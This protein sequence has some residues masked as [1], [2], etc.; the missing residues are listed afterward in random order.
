MRAP[1]RVVAAP[2]A[3]LFVALSCVIAATRPCDAGGRGAGDSG[4]A[5]VPF[6]APGGLVVVRAEARDDGG[7]AR[8]IRLLLDTGDPG[9]VTLFASTARAL[10]LTPAPPRPGVVHGLNGVA[11]CERRGARLP[12]LALDAMAWRDLSIDVLERSDSLP[13]GIGGGVEGV[14]GAAMVRGTRLTID[15]AARRLRLVPAGGMGDAATV[16]ASAEAAYQAPGGRSGVLRLVEGRLLTWIEAGGATLPALIDTASARTLIQRGA[17]LSSVTAG[18]VR[19]ADAAGGASDYPA[20][21]VRDLVIGGSAIE[22]LELVEVDLDRRLAAIL[23]PGSPA[24]RAV[25]GADILSDR[26]VVIDPA[27]GRFTLGP[28]CG[29]PAAPKGR[30]APVTAA[31]DASRPRARLRESGGRSAGRRPSRSD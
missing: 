21:R 17:G 11:S 9:G 25:L 19:L 12:A 23:S 31:P 15:G 14:I 16:R 24:P 30:P 1:R 6:D 4:S 18:A 28:A 7:H 2:P 5:G 22:S 3:F 13:E 27:A 29:P 8:R 10:G 26:A 20:I